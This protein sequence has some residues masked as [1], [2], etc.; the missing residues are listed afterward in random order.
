MG[1]GGMHGCGCRCDGTPRC[2][3]AVI[4]Q[5]AIHRGDRAPTRTPPI[6]RV[7]IT[8][9]TPGSVPP[10][11]QRLFHLAAHCCFESTR[12]PNPL[13]IAQG[14]QY[15][16]SNS[17]CSAHN[18]HRYVAHP[19]AVWTPSQQSRVACFL[20]PPS[21]ACGHVLIRS[22]IKHTAASQLIACF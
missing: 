13:S 5:R 20:S 1:C 6:S 12:R 4:D 14:H 22:G 9:P 21:P 19:L 7:Y 16:F 10:L 15:M 8:Q 18:S 11:L 3:A 17:L 2:A